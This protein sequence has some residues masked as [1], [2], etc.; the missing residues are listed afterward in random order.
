[1]KGEKSMVKNI[2][3]KVGSMFMALL[4]MVTMMP[5]IKANGST[6]E[7]TDIQ[8][9]DIFYSGDTIENHT[10]NMVMLDWQGVSDITES[11][12]MSYGSLTMPNNYEEYTLVNINTDISYS[13]VYTFAPTLKP[14]ASAD[15]VILI[16]T[17]GTAVDHDFK[18]KLSADKLNESLAVGTELETITLPDGLK[19]TYKGISD[20]TYQNIIVNISGTPTQEATGSMDISI[21]GSWVES[22]STL[23]VNCV[24]SYLI[25]QP[26]PAASMEAVSIEGKKGEAI[27]EKVWITLVNDKVASNPN[28]NVE[29]LTNLPN[30]LKASYMGNMS[31]TSLTIKISGTPEASGEGVL[32]MTIPGEW[33][34]SGK[35]LVV[36]KNSETKFK[37]TERTATIENV[38]IEGTV[39][40][41]IDK[42]IKI[43]LKD[44]QLNQSLAIGTALGT[45]NLP[46]GLSVTYKGISDLTYQNIFV[47]VSGT[48]TEVS[49]G[50]I[51]FTIP[52]S[53]LISGEDLK[54]QANNATY[55][56]K[57]P[58]P[59]A[60]VDSAL[61]LGNKDVDLN[62]YVLVTLVNDKVASNPDITKNPLT[63]LP[64]GVKASF[65]GSTS[66]TSLTIQIKGAPTVTAEGVLEMTIPGEW[67]ES[68]KDLVVTKNDDTKFKITERSASTKPVTIQGNV[69]TAVDQD[70]KIN[71]KE[72]KILQSLNV[73]AVLEDINLPD[74]LTATYKGISDMTY[75]NIIVNVSG[76]PTQVGNGALEITLSGSWLE[77]GKDLK[78]KT[79]DSSYVILQSVPTASME[80][81]VINGV[82]G[83]T[84]EEQ[85][86]I[87]IDNDKVSS[88]V[89][90]TKKATTNLPNG[91]QMSYLGNMTNTSLTVKISG[92]PLETRQGNL[93]VTIPG[94]WLESGKDLKVTVSSSTV[95]AIEKITVFQGNDATYVEGKSK[96]LVFQCNGKLENLIGVYVDG[97]AVDKNMYEVAS[98]S[99]IL[100]LKDEFMKKLANGEHTLRLTYKNDIEIKTNFKVIRSEDDEDKD[101][102]NNDKDNNK[103]NN[104]DNK[105]KNQSNDEVIKGTA[106]QPFGISSSMMVVAI[107]AGFLIL[108]KKEQKR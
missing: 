108:K 34:E 84:M 51:D 29:A 105:D 95:F 62:T 41:A 4:L 36:T 13:P 104:N 17:V 40:T 32:E 35:D 49:N 27:E 38:E 7:I 92:T 24:A 81:K 1:M 64:S 83:E 88:N 54:V 65:Q 37:I 30:G 25:K 18:I 59:S 67:L 72:D 28:L 2:V 42:D 102:N 78:V 44:D 22:G 97:K 75:Q 90:V 23:K 101:N 82:V 68:G 106:S 91:L 53:W 74:G 14:S 33:L 9:G 31:D 100:T 103:D 58:A 63:N 43:S 69:G 73:G 21:P 93:E 70:I 20:L 15:T 57:Q 8:V 3:K 71:L 47:N 76:T 87:T 85:I 98:G 16:G 107:A 45:T 5:S 10:E 52:G 99:T 6:Y 86:K 77:S 94:E 19:A 66:D 56:I 48:P 11:E 12:I 89:D 46:D 61:I 79:V 50:T 26:V 96:H 60:T 55:N 80:A 39:G